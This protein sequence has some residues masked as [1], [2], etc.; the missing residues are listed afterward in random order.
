MNIIVILNLGILTDIHEKLKATKD[1]FHKK[2]SFRIDNKLDFSNLKE[3]AFF[4]NNSKN[5]LIFLN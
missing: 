3:N 4:K 1:L 5:L 2:I